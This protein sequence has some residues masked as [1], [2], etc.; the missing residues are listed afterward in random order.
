M[1]QVKEPVTIQ[2]KKFKNE[3]SEQGYISPKDSFM[4]K[5]ISIVRTRLVDYMI[6]I[7]WLQLNGYVWLTD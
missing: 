2:E 5:N 3:I 6:L 4:N 7:N 1:V